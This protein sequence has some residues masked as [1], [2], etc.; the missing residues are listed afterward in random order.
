VLEGMSSA[1]ASRQP[2]D[3]RPQLVP[4]VIFDVGMHL[5][6]DSD[7]YLRKGF[8]VVAFEAN[9]ELV[10]VALRRFAAEIADGRLEVVSGGVARDDVDSVTFYVHSRL[11]IWG[12]T[13]SDRAHRNEVMG[14]SAEITVP[15]VNFA[16]CLR[17]HG[18]P[19][20][21]KIDIEAADMLCLEA[22]LDV[23]PEQRPWYTSIEA[24]SESWSGAVRQFNFLERLGY[25]RFAIVQQATIGNRV[26]PITTRDRRMLPY[27][28]EM[29]A[30][31]PFG[32][33]LDV[34]WMD[35]AQALHRYRSILLAHK[36]AS[37]FDR[38][39][40][41]GPELRYVAGALV[42]RPLPGWFDL[43]AARG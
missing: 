24:E 33:D 12:T 4:D 40:P 42:R 28:F 29:H 31:G 18:V 7:Y 19:Y 14:P 27:R 30:S 3:A 26:A 41:K 10:Q 20:Y 21:L 39:V 17:E 8:R 1:A 25:R 15:A 9:P 2:T 43:H 23:D 37:T 35:K 22:L 38:V 13:E 5:G 36:I 6:E 32:E 34:S 16:R 11:S